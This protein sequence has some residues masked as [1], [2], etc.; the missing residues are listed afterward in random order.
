[1]TRYNMMEHARWVQVR[2]DRDRE[3]QRRIRRYQRRAA[4]GLPLFTE[5]QYAKRAKDSRA[6]DR[7]GRDER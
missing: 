2:Y 7:A 6:D 4:L 1:M 3:R 5:S